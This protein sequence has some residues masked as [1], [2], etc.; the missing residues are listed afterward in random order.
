MSTRT[1]IRD[2]D[3]RVVYH[4]DVWEEELLELGQGYTALDGRPYFRSMG[5]IEY[6]LDKARE[7]RD[8]AQQE[9][10]DLR[11]SLKRVAS[12]LDDVINYNPGV[13]PSFRRIEARLWELAGEQDI[14]DRTR[15]HG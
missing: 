1:I 9:L 5:S 4:G 12:K 15:V 3:S 11:N 2:S 10:D 13:D 6:A 14:A 8:A 7:E